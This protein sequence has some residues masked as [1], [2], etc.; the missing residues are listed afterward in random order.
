MRGDYSRFPFDARSH[1]SSVL[2]QQGHVLLD[3]DWNEQSDIESRRF[4]AAVIDTLGRVFAASPDAFKIAS[5]RRGGL[6]IGRGR[7]YVDGLV[8]E[9]FGAGRPIWDDAL[10]EQHSAD[11]AP[12]AQQPYVPLAAPLPRSGTYLIFLDVW[13]REVTA[14]QDPNIADV[15]LGG[16]DTT[17][18]WQTVWQVKWRKVTAAEAKCPLEKVRVFMPSAARLSTR[19]NGYSGAENQLY[20]VEIHGEG[21]A[22]AATFKWSRDNASVTQVV[23]LPDPSRLVVA[24]SDPASHFAPGDQ[25]EVTD[26]AHE[27]GGFPGEL[28]RIKAFDSARRMMTLD[29]PLSAGLFPTDGN[30]VPDTR[31]HMCVQRWQGS[32]AIQGGNWIELG[33]GVAVKFDAD[34]ADGCF[35]TGDYWLIAAR[36]ADRSIA[37]LDRAPPRGIHHHYA[38]L[39]L[40]TPPRGLRDLRP[41]SPRRRR[42]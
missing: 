40:F 32:G 22:G 5:D 42:A 15:A 1:Y 17:T 28:R 39:A 3:Q 29:A 7:M 24:P 20:R 16:A 21:K 18:R 36:S 38:K 8:A 9:N 34:P 33:D 41:R 25:V 12:Y 27:L 10:A 37:P 19:S 6:T 11:S 35:K 23:R 13:Q 2:L 30:G 4:R 14:L 26:D 31:R